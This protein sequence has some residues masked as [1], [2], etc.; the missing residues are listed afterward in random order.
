MKKDELFN[1]F[2][3]VNNAKLTKLDD[4]DKFRVIKA[5]RTMKPIVD[6][7]KEFGVDARKKLADENH[8]KMVDVFNDWRKDM[9]EPTDEQKSAI[10]YVNEYTKKVNECLSDELNKDVE[11]TWEKLSEDGLKKFVASN[12]WN[13]QQTISVMGLFE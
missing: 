9:Q 3:L 6:E 2:E 10:E 7:L 1:A 13:V 11:S 8:D 12:D 4:D 5:C